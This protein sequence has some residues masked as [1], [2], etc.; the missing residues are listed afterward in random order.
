MSKQFNSREPNTPG[1]TTDRTDTPSAACHLCNSREKHHRL[2]NCHPT[3]SPFCAENFQIDVCR[4]PRVYF[5]KTPE[6]TLF[7]ATSMLSGTP[8]SQNS[9]PW[10]EPSRPLD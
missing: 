10:R 9:S 7:A 1:A 8:P 4:R 6:T 3:R 2:T 5:L